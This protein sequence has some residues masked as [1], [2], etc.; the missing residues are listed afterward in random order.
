M[1]STLL[2]QGMQYAA[3]TM[4]VFPVGSSICRGCL[5]FSLYE[6]WSWNASLIAIRFSPGLGGGFIIKY[7]TQVNYLE[8]VPTLLSL[9]VL[10]G[11]AGEENVVKIARGARRR[12]QL[13]R[14]VQLATNWFVSG[15]FTVGREIKQLVMQ[16]TFSAH[17][18]PQ[19]G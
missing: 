3:W 4:M 17:L 10:P 15:Y 1:Y 13:A 11:G 18:P 19:T 2:S 5:Y 14:R 12:T 9:V 8:K 7:I 16:R 6:L